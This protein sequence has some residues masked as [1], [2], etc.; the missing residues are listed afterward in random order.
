[1]NSNS[2]SV[3]DSDW[4][5][6]TNIYYNEKWIGLNNTI[7]KQINSR[8]LVPYIYSNWNYNRR[9]IGLLVLISST[10]E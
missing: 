9:M 6:Q 10:I 1:M 2:S 3:Y 7:S 4:Y 8:T 5:D